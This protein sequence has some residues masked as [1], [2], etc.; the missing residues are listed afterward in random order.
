[1]RPKERDYMD[2]HANYIVLNEVVQVI[3]LQKDSYGVT[4]GQI[5]HY[6]GRTLNVPRHQ[7]LFESD[8]EMLSELAG[9]LHSMK[10]PSR[11]KRFFEIT[12]ELILNES[13]LS[14]LKEYIEKLENKSDE[15]L[16][17]NFMDVG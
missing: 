9:I 1:M 8:H 2:V 16:Q 17:I 10:N 11:N 15:Q 3:S 4:H 6:D 5:K 14:L 13:P 12:R 7:L